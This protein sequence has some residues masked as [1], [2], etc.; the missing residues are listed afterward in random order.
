[1]TSPLH[2]IEKTYNRMP[3]SCCIFFKADSPIRR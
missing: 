3:V 2:S 1:M